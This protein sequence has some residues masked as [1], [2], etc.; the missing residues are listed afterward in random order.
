MRLIAAA[1]TDKGIV[2]QSNQDCLCFMQ[3]ETAHGP[4]ALALICDGMGGLQMGEVAS[5]AVT[6]MFACWFEQEL[7]R[8]IDAFDWRGVI[9]QWDNMIKTAAQKLGQYGAKSGVRLGTTIT[10]MLLFEYHYLIAHVGDSRIYEMTD[11]LRQLTEDQTL[12]AQE[13]QQG[14]LT[15]EQAEHD[16]RRNVLLQCVGAS[17]IVNPAMIT[18]TFRTNAT[19]LLC[20]DGLRHEVS[21]QELYAYTAPSVSGS[22]KEMQQNLGSLISLVKQRGE[23]D[24]LSALLVRIMD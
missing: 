18:G 9:D 1:L 10:A 3:A 12:V 22:K 21:P 15:P 11:K 7:P 17:A 5:A 20:S 14:L 19:Y 6:R 23:E 24:N 2:K 4:I 16:P 8:Q 13:V